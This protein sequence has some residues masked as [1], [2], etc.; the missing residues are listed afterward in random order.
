MYLYFFLSIHAL[1]LTTYKLFHSYLKHSM[2]CQLTKGDIENSI[3]SL[4]L[5]AVEVVSG[6]GKEVSVKRQAQRGGK[7]RLH[8]TA[9]I[10]TTHNVDDIF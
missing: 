8:Q 6:G 10:P 1:A 5:P 4:S 9:L 3:A 7:K 2:S